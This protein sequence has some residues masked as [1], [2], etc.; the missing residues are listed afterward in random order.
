MSKRNKN[1]ISTYDKCDFCDIPTIKGEL[2]WITSFGEQGWMCPECVHE[3]KEA[4][5]EGYQW[6]VY[7]NTLPYGYNDAYDDGFSTAHAD[8]WN[9]PT[10]GN[11][12]GPRKICNHNLTPF[13][14]G[15][16]KYVYLSGS[17]G[18]KAN[19]EGPEPD[20]AVYLS[21]TWLC[22]GQMLTNDGSIEKSPDEPST[23]YFDWPDYG[24][25]D[26]KKLIPALEWAL[27]G[28]RAGRNVEI[29]CHGG[30]GRTGT[31]VA[32]MCVMYGELAE[33]AISRIRLE[34]CEKA[35][36]TKPQEEMIQALEDALYLIDEKEILV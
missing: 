4:L 35:I 30:H 12:I 24:V 7:N 2:E 22:T 20:V 33:D 19:P 23:L 18:L 36:E 26:V 34:Y 3:E 32:A 21:D 6:P 27:N 10:V 11:T 31:F 15:D 5:S 8:W 16:G 9:H 13:E 29:G 17:A 28:L 25:V 1:R 14:I